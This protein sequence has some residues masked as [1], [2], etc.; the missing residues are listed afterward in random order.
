MQVNIKEIRW[1]TMDWIHLAWD[2][3]AWRDFMKRRMS[4]R[5]PRNLR[6]FLTRGEIISSSRMTVLQGVG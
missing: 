3:K 5:F 2:R 4:L 1:E 6:N